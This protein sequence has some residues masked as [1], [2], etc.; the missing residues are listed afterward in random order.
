MRPHDLY[1]QIGVDDMTRLRASLD[2]G[3]SWTKD[4]A[5]NRWGWADRRLRATV[6]ELRRAGYPVISIS[7]Q[8]SVYRKAT[9]RTEVEDFINRE[10]VSRTRKLEEQI[11][12][13]R[14]AA[15]QHFGTDQLALAI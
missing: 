8:G 1:A 6:A 2:K 15:D 7:E 12:E 5:L 11:R 14:A 13:M 4:S 10:L 9:S 3:E